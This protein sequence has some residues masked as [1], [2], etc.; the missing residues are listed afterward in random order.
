MDDGGSPKTRQ[1]DGESKKRECGIKSEHADANSGK[2]GDE[3]SVGN[4]IAKS[5]VPFGEND[6]STQSE[7]EDP[8]WHQEEDGLRT[9]KTPE[10]RSE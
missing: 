10:Q 8:E 1:R 3:G 2:C 5:K 6:Q 7:L 4:A 9:F